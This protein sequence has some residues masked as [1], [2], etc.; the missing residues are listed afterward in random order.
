M[1]VDTSVWVDHLRHRN[2]RLATALESMPVMTHSFVI[3]ELSCGHLAQRTEVLGYLNA[4]PTLPL[5]DH[6]EVVEFVGMHR[7]Y[8]RGLGWVDMHL[9]AAAQL[10]QLPIWTLDKRLAMVAGEMGLAY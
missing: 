8:G 3:G 7:L 10:A 5:T 1:L 6:E 4:L 9:L 2:A